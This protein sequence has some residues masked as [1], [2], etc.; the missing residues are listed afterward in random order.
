[1][2]AN[3]RTRSMDAAINETDRRREKQE[4]YN[5]AEGIVPK[6]IVKPIKNTLNIS[7]KEELKVDV[8]DIPET[9]EKLKALMTI[10]SS[11]LDFEKAIELREKIGQLKK[12]MGKMNK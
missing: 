9:I 12:M 5:C 6:T 4:A 1:M 10:A 8:K 11:S 7:S 2:Y 3:T